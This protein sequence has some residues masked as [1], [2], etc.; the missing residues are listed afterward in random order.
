MKKKILISYNFILH[1]REDFFELLNEFYDVTVLHS[2]QPPANT[3]HSYSVIHTK[4]MKLGPFFLQTGLLNAY[5]KK[6]FDVVILLLDLRWLNV[7]TFIIINTVFRLK[8]KVITWGAWKTNRRMLDA[9]RYWFMCRVDANIFYCENTKSDFLT[10]GL[11]EH[12]AFVANNTFKVQVDIPCYINSEKDSLLFVGSLDKRKKNI[13]LLRGFAAVTSQ[14][15]E[16]IK[17]VFIGD[18]PERLLLEEEA[19]RL[20][21]TKRVRFLG[22]IN[23]PDELIKYYNRA[24]CT[25]SYGQAGLSVLQSMG[26]GVPFMTL[27][28]AISGGEISNIKNG[29]NGLLLDEGLDALQK[30]LIRVCN[31]E[32]WARHLGM[33]A[34]QHYQQHCKLE[35]MVNGFVAAIENK[36]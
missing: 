6:R 32:D 17:L 25:I 1:Y 9:I 28:D 13:L 14:I 23:N 5:Y 12:R 30:N 11:P 4:F 35:H 20:R 36:I 16:K 10:V 27:K 21:I 31:D 18:G 3:K 19:N 8:C 33:K 2:G 29:H 7:L 34:Y 26:F 22:R 24:I 15:S